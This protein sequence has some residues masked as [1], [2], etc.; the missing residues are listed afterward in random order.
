VE[1]GVRCHYSY[2]ANRGMAEY[3]LD[4]NKLFTKMTRDVNFYC[5]FRYRA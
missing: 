4:Q 1:R 3:E 5:A 2:S